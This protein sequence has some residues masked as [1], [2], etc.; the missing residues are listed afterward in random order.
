MNLSFFYSIYCFHIITSNFIES[1]SGVTICNQFRITRPD[2]WCHRASDH[3]TRHR[4]LPIP[5]GDPLEQRHRLTSSVTW[6]CD[7][8]VPIPYRR[9]IVT[10]SLFP[11]N[12][13]ILASKCI[14]VTTLTF[15]GH[16]TSSVVGLAMVHFL[17]VVLWTQVSISNGLR[18][19][20]P[21]TS[22]AHWH[23]A[24]SS[25]RMRDIT[26]C[27]PPYVKFKYIFISYP[28]FA[29]SLCHFHWVPIKNKGCSL[30]GPLMLKA[31]SSE[32]F[33]SENLQNFDLLGALEIRGYKK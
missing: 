31:K 22:C 11:A 16:V 14:G 2:T 25:L 6:P 26:W 29:Y 10:K 5:I 8:Q 30:S 7:S 12:F 18:D 28:H 4:T 3:S 27:V 13:E 23:N 15:Q 33:Q 20:Q 24:K 9:S 19:I 21:Q 17:L 32:K 1:E